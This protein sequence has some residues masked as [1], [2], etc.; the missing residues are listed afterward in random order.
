MTS[1]SPGGMRRLIVK[2]TTPFFPPTREK[3]V[4]CPPAGVNQPRRHVLPGGAYLTTAG[5]PAARSA[6]CSPAASR[7]ERTSTVT[8]P[9]IFR[10]TA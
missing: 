2:C 6:R 10:V 4:P 8:D 3:P 7:S 9:S 5:M 1:V